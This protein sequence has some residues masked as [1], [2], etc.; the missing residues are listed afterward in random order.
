MLQPALSSEFNLRLGLSKVSQLLCLLT[1]RE[2]WF[3]LGENPK[4][5]LRFGLFTYCDRS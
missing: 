2:E 3:S 1:L 5:F 4:I